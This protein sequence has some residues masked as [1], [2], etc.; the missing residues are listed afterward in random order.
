MR[1][2]LVE[3]LTEQD[4]CQFGRLEAIY[5][6][7]LDPENQYCDDFSAVIVRSIPRYE[8]PIEGPLGKALEDKFY[9]RVSGRLKNLISGREITI[10][11]GFQRMATAYDQQSCI[12]DTIGISG[13]RFVTECDIMWDFVSVI[14]RIRP[15]IGYNY[16]Y[17]DE[18][19]EVFQRKATA[20]QRNGHFWDAPKGEEFTE[21]ITKVGHWE[22]LPL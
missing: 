6:T 2:D 4:Y 18:H 13:R 20:I 22:D 7:A 10:T 9:W 8:P 5:F 11:H 12:E 19:W 17:I 21:V 14:A 15:I 3:H 1:E 16:R